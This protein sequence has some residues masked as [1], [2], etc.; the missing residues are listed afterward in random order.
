LPWF[1]FVVSNATCNACQELEDNKW[2][3]VNTRVVFVSFFLYNPNLNLFS[4][5]LGSFEHNAAG[6]VKPWY[7]FLHFSMHTPGI[8]IACDMIIGAYALFYL[9]QFLDGM[10]YARYW[11]GSVFYHLNDFW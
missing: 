1:L 8:I 6:L 2:C 9:Y 5:V 3:D 7:Q 4:Y 10:Y 11:M